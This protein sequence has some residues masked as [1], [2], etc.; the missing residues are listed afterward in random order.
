MGSSISP[1]NLSGVWLLL[2]PTRPALAL[3]FTA[4]PCAV[5]GVTVLTP[6]QP[7]RRSPAE[8]CSI[9]PSAAPRCPQ[10]RLDS[11]LGHAGTCGL[12]GVAQPTSGP[13]HAPLPQLDTHFRG[14]PRGLV[15]SLP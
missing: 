7:G 9:H 11:L 14:Y 1:L 2:P 6:G 15:V 13:L 12:A 8:P 10:G 3:R 5:Q 4:R